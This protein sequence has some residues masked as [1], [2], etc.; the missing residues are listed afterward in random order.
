MLDKPRRI[1]ALE[2]LL[3][4][5]LCRLLRITPMKPIPR[6]RNTIFRSQRFRIRPLRLV[7]VRRAY[8]IPPDL[9]RVLS[10]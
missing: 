9:Y 5:L 2:Q 7:D 10:V 4:L 8:Q 6:I 3:Q 1:P